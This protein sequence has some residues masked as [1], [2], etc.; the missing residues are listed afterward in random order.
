MAE[1]RWRPVPIYAPVY[2]NV[3]E[4]ALRNGQ[5]ALENGYVTEARGHSRFPG[6]ALWGTLDGGGRVYLFPYGEDLYA[7]TSLG[8]VYV[9]GRDGTIEDRTTVL[10]TGGQ[11]PTFAPTD[12]G[13]AIAAGGPTVTMRT[14]ASQLLSAD[15]PATTHVAY[16]DAYMLAL[17]PGSARFRYCSP[18][19]YGIWP[20]INTETAN[21]QYDRLSSLIVNDFSEI[22]ML[23]PESIEQWERNSSGTRAFYRRWTVAD[24]LYTPYGV[25]LADNAVF[26]INKK[27]ELARVS[28]QLSSP[29]SRPIQ[30]TLEK[31]DDWSECW[32]QVCLIRGQ[33]FL[34]VQ[35]PNAT[36]SYGTKGVT[37]LYDY[38]QRRFAFLYGFDRTAGLPTRW[39]G[40][41]IATLWERTFIG[42]E[43]GRIYTL[44][45]VAYAQDAGPMHMLGRTGHFDLGFRMQVNNLRIRMR[46]G[47]DAAAGTGVIQLRINRDNTGWLKW[48][49]F[50]IGSAGQREM[51]ILTG[52]LG[53]AN[54]WQFEYR[55]VDPLP[56]EIVEIAVLPERVG[57]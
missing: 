34:I 48:L 16:I 1:G 13:L 22:L 29:I 33:R 43:D 23:G 17:E 20:A 51:T 37:F 52:P 39:Y 7:V 40:W 28:G 42:G 27:R 8:R 57:D 25:A 49:S 10:V 46:R 26:I 2:T 44:D 19:F 18:G 4:T 50:P 30:D 55:V 47:Q 5:A 3:D 35:L 31:I 36:N 12:D 24:G 32:M 45:D 21:A 56:V 15:A 54:T 38:A 6:N 14:G 53:T 41:S 9:C 11:R